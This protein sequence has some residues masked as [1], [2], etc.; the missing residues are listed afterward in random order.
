[1]LHR[2]GRRRRR[3]PGDQNLVDYTWREYGM[4]VGLWRIADVT[5][6]GS[7]RATVALNAG[8]CDVW[9]KAIEGWTLS[10]GK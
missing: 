8:V 9:P 6:P 10:G 3:L 5:A 4:R 2:P 1:M 7:I